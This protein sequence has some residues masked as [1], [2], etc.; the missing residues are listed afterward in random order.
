MNYIDIILAIPLVWFI[1][2]GFT[3]GLIIEVSS[4]LGLVLGV[5]IG[6]NFSFYISDALNLTSQY[7]PLISFA[8]TFILIVFLIYLLA[9]LLEKSINVLALGFLNKLSGAFFGLLKIA[10]IISILLMFI[11]KI[12]IIPQN[13]KN[14]SLLYP[15]V[16]AFAP[17]IIPK[18]HF[19]DIRK[20]LDSTF[21]KNNGKVTNQK[22]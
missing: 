2:K 12:N 7:A 21:H 5:Y 18:L 20:E 13:A 16:S 9:K 10:F 17:L 8:I 3:H 14:E 22:N 1:Y 15:T 11:N 4:L 6:L 19:E